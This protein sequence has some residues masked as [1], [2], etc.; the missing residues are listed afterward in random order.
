M[1]NLR[2]Q[3]KAIALIALVPA[4]LAVSQASFAGP[5]GT[6]PLIDKDFE[7]AMRKFIARRFFNKIDATDAQRAKLTAIFDK[8]TEETR[9]QREQLR[10]EVLGLAD[11]MA[12]K[13]ATDEQ[14]K[15]KADELRAL[16]QKLMDHRLSVALEV[17]KVLT[18]EQREKMNSRVH[19]LITGGGSSH[20]RKISFLMDE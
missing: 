5:T 11:L 8:T 16:K 3:K 18:S 12:S 7:T 10:H 13:D 2:T 19:E 20:L 4:L 1:K 17:R 6:A 15:Q 14:I 9:P